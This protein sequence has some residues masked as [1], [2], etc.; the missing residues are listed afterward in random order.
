MSYKRLASDRLHPKQ[1]VYDVTLGV[2]VRGSLPD[3][4]AGRAVRVN[5]VKSGA[6]SVGGSGFCV[7]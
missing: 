6:F 4:R 5:S 2:G 7:P 3:I 1:Q